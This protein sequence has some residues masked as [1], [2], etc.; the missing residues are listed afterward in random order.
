MKNNEAN[1]FSANR[2][3]LGNNLENNPIYGELSEKYVNEWYKYADN[4]G[5]LKRE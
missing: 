5:K 4:N 2:L 3:V 1:N